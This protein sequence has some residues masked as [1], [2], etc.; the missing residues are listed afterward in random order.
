MPQ[1]GES[2]LYKSENQNVCPQCSH[3]RIGAQSTMP[4][5]PKAVT[6]CSV[7]ASMR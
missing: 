7:A 6:N 3:H 1:L 5:T 2:V 4:L